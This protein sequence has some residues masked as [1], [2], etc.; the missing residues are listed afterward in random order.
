MG[1][2][3]AWIDLHPILGVIVIVGNASAPCLAPSKVFYEQCKSIENL[4]KQADSA[5]SDGNEKVSP[6]LLWRRLSLNKVSLR[7]RQKT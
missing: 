6:Y 2:R 1:L 5:V 7:C 4:R 3:R